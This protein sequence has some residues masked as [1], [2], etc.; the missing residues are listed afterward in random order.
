MSELNPLGLEGIEFVE[1]ASPEPSMLEKLFGEFGFSVVAQ[2]GEE[3][4]GTTHWRQK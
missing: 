1:F 4:E 2:R 3:G